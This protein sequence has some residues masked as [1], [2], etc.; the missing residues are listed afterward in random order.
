VT[1]AEPARVVYGGRE[2][3]AAAGDAVVLD[4]W[5]VLPGDLLPLLAGAGSLVVADALSFPWDALRPTDRDIPVA[6]ALPE[7]PAAE[8]EA[9]LG[10]V[11]LDHLGPWDAVAAGDHLWTALRAGRRW[12]NTLRTA[13]GAGTMLGRLAGIT[14]ASKHRWLRFHGA[15][16]Q[17]I[18]RRDAPSVLDVGAVLAGW[19]GRSRYAAVAGDDVERRLVAAVPEADAVEWD[20]SRLPLEDGSVDVVAIPAVVDA[21]RPGTPPPSE[22]WRVLAPGGTIVLE[23]EADPAVPMSG[24]RRVIEAVAAAAPGPA[25]APIAATYRLPGEDV[26]RLGILVF[27]RSAA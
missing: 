26:H 7:L 5:Q 17:E 1:A 23:V 16:R 13:A 19:V 25:P 10:R 22:W 8:V 4:E 20:G 15:V 14:R 11:C 18:I 27:R 6:V 21:D 24:P 2:P 3:P 9:L 12:P